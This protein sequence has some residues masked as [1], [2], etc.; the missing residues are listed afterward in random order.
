LIRPGVNTPSSISIDIE[1]FIPSSDTLSI[2][3]LDIRS[4]ASSIFLSGVITVTPEIPHLLIV[5][6]LLFQINVN[7]IYNYFH[8]SSK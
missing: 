1:A 8:Q 4:P 7:N 3:P 6:T 5:K 2:F